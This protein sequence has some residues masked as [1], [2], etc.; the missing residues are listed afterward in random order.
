[1]KASTLC[2]L[3][4]FRGVFAVVVNQPGGHEWEVCPLNGQSDA[5]VSLSKTMNINQAHVWPLTRLR[6][7]PTYSLLSAVSTH[8]PPGLLCPLLST[9]SSPFAK[10]TCSVCLISNVSCSNLLDQ[11][12]S[13]R[14]LLFTYPPLPPH[15]LLICC[16]HPHSS[17]ITTH[18]VIYFILSPISLSPPPPSPFSFDVSVPSSSLSRHLNASASSQL[19]AKIFKKKGLFL[20]SSS[21]EHQRGIRIENWHYL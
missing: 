8:P 18:Q 12:S 14:P 10:S 15:T 7:S 1:M 6:M 19:Q 2:A 3:T 13:P 16:H 11:F 21:E 9:L 17:C 4:Y 5:E 20:Q